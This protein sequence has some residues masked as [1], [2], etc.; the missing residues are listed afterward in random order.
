MLKLAQFHQ[1]KMDR[2]LVF[3]I[4]FFGTYNFKILQASITAAHSNADPLAM[5]IRD[6]HRK[7]G[8]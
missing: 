5:A 7:R 3:V 6:W 8:K 2:E 1:V 4:V